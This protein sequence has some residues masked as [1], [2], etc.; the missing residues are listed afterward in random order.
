MM[1]V[2]TIFW[3]TCLGVVTTN[4][5][6]RARILNRGE[7]HIVFKKKKNKK[8]SLSLA[9]DIFLVRARDVFCIYIFIIIIDLYIVCNFFFFCASCDNFYMC[10][11]DYSNVKVVHVLDSFSFLSFFC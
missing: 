7:S 2:V 6:E 9:P 5:K 1:V 10:Y 11:I 8:T 3:M 4:C